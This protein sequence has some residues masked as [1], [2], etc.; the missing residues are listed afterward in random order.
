MQ[1]QLLI[2]PVKGWVSCLPPVSSP[3]LWAKKNQLCE[4]DGGKAWGMTRWAIKGA[5]VL[6]CGRRLL[7]EWSGAEGGQGPVADFLAEAVKAPGPLPKAISK[8]SA[9]SLLRQ[10]LGGALAY[11]RAD[12]HH[13]GVGAGIVMMAGSM[14]APGGGVL[15]GD[16]MPI[17]CPA[18]PLQWTTWCQTPSPAW[19]R[20]GS[21]GGSGRT[22]KP[23]ATTRCMWTSPAGATASIRSCTPWSTRKVC[24]PPPPARGPW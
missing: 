6:Q 22:A 17:L 20:H 21:G 8:G 23:A 3:S 1:G 10:A 15:G 11:G 19:W 12:G 2:L 16:P 9:C 14:Q 13:F 4:M 18:V 5:L 7:M 24:C